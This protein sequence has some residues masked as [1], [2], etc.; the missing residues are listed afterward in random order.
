LKTDVQV[1]EIFENSPFQ[2]NENLHIYSFIC[3]NGDENI[4][5]EEFKK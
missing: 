2:K 1:K 5:L 3:E 4:L